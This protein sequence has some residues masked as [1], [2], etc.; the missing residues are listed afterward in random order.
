LYSC[1]R[2]AK[3]MQSPK[4]SHGKLILYLEYNNTLFIMCKVKWGNTAGY[5][6]YICPHHLNNDLIISTH[7]TLYV[8]FECFVIKGCLILNTLSMGFR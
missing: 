3:T 2:F 1:R 6:G 5:V 7:V 8:K 4:V